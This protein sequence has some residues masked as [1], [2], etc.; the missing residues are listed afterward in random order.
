MTRAD[1]QRRRIA[2][3]AVAGEDLLALAPPA[4]AVSRNSRRQADAGWRRNA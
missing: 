4:R 3:R 1:L 2:V